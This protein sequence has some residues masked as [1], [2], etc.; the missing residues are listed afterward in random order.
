M[1]IEHIDKFWDC[2]NF[3]DEAWCPAISPYGEVVWSSNVNF[4]SIS[5]NPYRAKLT[6]LIRNELKTMP[7]ITDS[8]L[9]S[10]YVAS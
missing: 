2:L 8:V 10:E 1:L 3:K 6:N 5:F 7:Q 9:K 4:K